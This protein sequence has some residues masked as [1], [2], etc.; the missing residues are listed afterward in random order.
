MSPLDKESIQSKIARIRRNLKELQKLGALS[1]KAYAANILNTATAERLLQVSIEAMLD[2]GSHIV[3]EK[4]LGEPLEY[5][6]VFTILL[7]AGVLPKNLEKSLMDLVGLRNRIVHLY[8]EVDPKKIHQFLS[9][10]LSD[11]DVFIRVI[12]K[13]LKKN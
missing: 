6:S 5:R 13:Y 7:K 10:D 11:F 9:R 1:Y 4:A 3:A 2:I 8:E 12:T